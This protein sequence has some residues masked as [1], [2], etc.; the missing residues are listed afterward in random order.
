ATMRFTIL[1]IFVVALVAS[2]AAQGWASSISNFISN[3]QNPPN[4]IDRITNL[5]RS[6]DNTLYQMNQNR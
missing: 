3:I 1:L 6:L 5:L 4:V 2:A